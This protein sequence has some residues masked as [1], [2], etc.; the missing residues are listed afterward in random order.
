MKRVLLESNDDDDS[1]RNDGEELTLADNTTGRGSRCS[2][3]VMIRRGPKS[4]TVFCVSPENQEDVVGADNGCPRPEGASNRKLDRNRTLDEER[5]S[6]IDQVSSP[7]HSEQQPHATTD[8]RVA[9]ERALRISRAR[10]FPRWQMALC[11]ADFHSSAGEEEADGSGSGSSNTDDDI[12]IRKRAVGDLD[13]ESPSLVKVK[14]PSVT[15][16]GCGDRGD[17]KSSGDSRA[18]VMMTLTAAASLKDGQA[19]G[20]EV[21]RSCSGGSADAVEQEV[22]AELIDT[23]DEST[24]FN[25]YIGGFIGDG[26]DS[27]DESF[28]PEG[29]QAG[30]DSPLAMAM[31]S[32][33]A[34]GGKY[35]AEDAGLDGEDYDCGD[36]DI[37][38]QSLV[39]AEKP[40][41]SPRHQREDVEGVWGQLC[42][43]SENDHGAIQGEV[44]KSL[45]R[46][47]DSTLSAAE[48]GGRD[49]NG[50]GGKKDGK[51][52]PRQR[53]KK[54]RRRL[55]S[56]SE[57]EC[58]SNDATKHKPSVSA[59]LLGDGPYPLHKKATSTVGGVPAEDQEQRIDR[60]REIL[61][62]QMSL[63]RRSDYFS[64][65]EERDGE[66]SS[67]SEPVFSRGSG[68]QQ[69][70]VAL[71]QDKNK[72]QKEQHSGNAGTDDFS[73]GVGEASST[74]SAL[75]SEDEET[76]NGGVMKAPAE[77]KFDISS[78]RILSR[79]TNGVS[80]PDVSPA[81]EDDGAPLPHEQVTRDVERVAAE[82]QEE[83]INRAREMLTLQMSLSQ[84]S[85]SFSADKER[86]DE[87]NRNSEPS[88]NHGSGGQQVAAQSRYA[89]ENQEEENS[90]NATA[91][92]FST[93]V[94]E[95]ASTQ[96]APSPE[97]Q[98]RWPSPTPGSCCGSPDSGGSRDCEQS[99]GGGSVGLVVDSTPHNY[100]DSVTDRDSIIFAV[101]SET[102]T[103]MTADAPDG[104]RT[105]ESATKSGATTTAEA[106]ARREGPEQPRQRMVMDFGSDGEDD[107]DGSNASLPVGSPEGRPLNHAAGETQRWGG[108]PAGRNDNG[109]GGDVDDDQVLLPMFGRETAACNQDE[110]SVHRD[111]ESVNDGPS[112]EDAAATTV[113]TDDGFGDDLVDTDD[114]DHLVRRKIKKGRVGR[115]LVL[116]SATRAARRV[117]DSSSEDDGEV[118]YSDDDGGGDADGSDDH[119]SR[120]SRR[121]TKYVDRIVDDDEGSSNFGGSSSSSNNNSNNSSSESM[122]DDKIAITDGAASSE[123]GDSDG[124]WSTDIVK[125]SQPSSRAGRHRGTSQRIA[126][127]DEAGSSGN[128]RGT[129]KPAAF[130]SPPPPRARRHGCT[131]GGVGSD[132][133]NSSSSS[134][135]GDRHR[136]GGGGGK[137]FRD[138]ETPT[139]G[140]T[141][142]TPP[143]K[144][145]PT[146]GKPR[147]VAK[148]GGGAGG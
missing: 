14:G 61:R 117:L 65:D 67:S 112:N 72:H 147:Q 39:K 50:V 122:E 123:E 80:P 44:V 95:A 9:E 148:D 53:R 121:P 29:Q 70:Q 138:A 54:A 143:V 84:R 27:Q 35:S 71:T 49:P 91:D 19:S 13:V 64:A 68:N 21:L 60:A 75:F 88:F 146:T 118:D 10:E 43:E 41:R 113:G 107:S 6:S 18:T 8:E 99:I 76:D 114:S 48:S 86:D 79:P 78:P 82:L 56:D 40:L 83:R 124:K 81:V 4:S 115:R 142:T 7:L 111:S 69:Q 11:R 51:T 24:L 87:D 133:T 17:N 128:D 1:T 102:L 63:C 100:R 137:A 30:T 73:P 140:N 131:G 85:D 2:R 59:A 3:E 136:W 145:R 42:S 105:I 31:A 15:R 126:E 120:G 141:A 46:P 89:N 62:R 74:R 134:N 98:Q 66:Y 33:D 77:P 125:K 93:K 132:N 28:A 37:V 135:A 38:R 144:R 104:T 119:D 130:K 34:G 101:E 20:E 103:R 139:A 127:D 106:E 5:S 22:G 25:G 47:A 108:E 52:P 32:E 16:V 55:L 129:A 57:D 92:D 109:K 23:R 110:A 116:G 97:Q 12:G 96:R 26:D 45:V 94:D 36:G 90:G 58:T